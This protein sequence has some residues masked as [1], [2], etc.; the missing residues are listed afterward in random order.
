MAE[1]RSRE[2]AEFQMNI[3]LNGENADSLRLVGD[4][5]YNFQMQD[6][7]NSLH[8]IQEG[9]EEQAQHQESTQQQE[10][11]MEVA[12]TPGYR[13]TVNEDDFVSAFL[14]DSPNDEE[15]E[16]NNNGHGKQ[17][18]KGKRIRME[19]GH[20][21]TDSED[22]RRI[23]QRL[24]SLDVNEMVAVMERQSQGALVIKDNDNSELGLRKLP[25]GN[26]RNPIGTSSLEQK[27]VM[28]TDIDDP[29][30]FA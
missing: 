7:T 22:G 17:D 6:A 10:E 13:C 2:T 23:R 8:L 12:L 25:P 29:V 28:A 30:L 1:R 4:G 21:D 19:E 26:P 9:V 3:L 24:Q 5:M 18:R 16:R 11:N 15:Q 27:K 14:K 20:S